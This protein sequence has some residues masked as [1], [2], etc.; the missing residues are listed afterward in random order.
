VENQE[1]ITLQKTVDCGG[2]GQELDARK[3][4]KIEQT[5]YFSS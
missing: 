2:D 5:R 1:F 3:A 4:E